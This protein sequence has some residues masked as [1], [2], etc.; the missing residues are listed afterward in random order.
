[1]K[2]ITSLRN[3]PRVWHRLYVF[4]RVVQVVRFPAL[5]T[6]CMFSCA[7]CSLYVSRACYRLYVFTGLVHVVGSPRLVQVLL[8]ALKTS[9][10]FS[11]TMAKVMPFN[12]MLFWQ[13][14]EISLVA[15]LRNTFSFLVINCY[16]LVYNIGLCSS[17][18]YDRSNWK[19]GEANKF[20]CSLCLP[21]FSLVR[22]VAE[23]F[24][25]ISIMPVLNCNQ[26][27]CG[28]LRAFTKKRKLSGFLLAITIILQTTTK[29]KNAT[30]QVRNSIILKI[31]I[32]FK[33]LL[34]TVIG[35]C[36]LIE[37]IQ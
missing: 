34:G 13:L 18:E 8:P 24:H 20:H 28:L 19:S 25:L 17:K 10:T 14:S 6:C 33:P 11:R 35:K 15:K 5:G 12:A 2:I 9:S 36:S 37:F 23:G 21:L 22:L 29:S 1:M 16:V 7:W 27:L 30:K 31:I 26:Q 4:P 3:C 32:I